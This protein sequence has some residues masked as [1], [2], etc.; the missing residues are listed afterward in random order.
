MK[1]TSIVGSI[2]EA[3][4]TKLLEFINQNPEGELT[5]YISSWGGCANS[6]EAMQDVINAN[7]DRITLICNGDLF[8]A[9]FILFFSVK[10]R[11][12][13]LDRAIGLHHHYML[14]EIN[15]ASNGEPDDALCRYRLKQLKA[16]RMKEIRFFRSLGM[17]EE[18]VAKIE[19]NEDVYFNDKRLRQF[20]KNQSK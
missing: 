10:C 8:S 18:E 3:S 20:L 4:L 5:I 2:E 19:R 9:A 1:Y 7:S 13:V 16:D 15:I 14:S 17:S 11:R 6:M 12:I